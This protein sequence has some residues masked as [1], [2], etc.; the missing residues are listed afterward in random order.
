ML[1]NSVGVGPLI[2]G[3]DCKYKFC[4]C[5]LLVMRQAIARVDTELMGSCPDHLEKSYQQGNGA[6]YGRCPLSVV[7]LKMEGAVSH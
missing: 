6:S 7:I 2:F 5:F 3:N 1:E 4:S